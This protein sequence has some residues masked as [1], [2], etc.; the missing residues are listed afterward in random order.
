M[1]VPI[2]DDVPISLTGSASRKPRPV[3]GELHLITCAPWRVVDNLWDRLARYSTGTITMRTGTQCHL[4]VDITGPALE[5]M[6]FDADLVE[7]L[8]DALVDNVKDGFGLVIE[9]RYRR[10]DHRADVSGA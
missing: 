1:S 2:T 4:I 7:R 3:G 8:A 6:M 5:Q 9:G 10:Q